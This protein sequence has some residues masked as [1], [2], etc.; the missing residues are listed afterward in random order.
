VR[1]KAG[2]IVADYMWEKAIGRVFRSE[3]EDYSGVVK[4]VGIPYMY[5]VIS[6]TPKVGS[7]LEV[8]DFQENELYVVVREDL[9]G[10]FKYLD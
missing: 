7:V 5:K 10:E 2:A 4:I 6:G 3:S 9:A 1:K 8:T